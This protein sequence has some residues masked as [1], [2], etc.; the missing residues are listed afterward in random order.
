MRTLFGVLLLIALGLLASMFFGE[1]AGK[2]AGTTVFPPGTRSALPADPDP[3]RL[4]IDALSG[5]ERKCLTVFLTYDRVKV[6]DLTLGQTRE[7][8]ACRSLGM[9]HDLR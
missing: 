3:T 6:G 4:K 1:N 2:P 7:I 9:Y 5:T 8:E